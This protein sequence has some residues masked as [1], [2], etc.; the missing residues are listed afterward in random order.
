MVPV[1]ALHEL[2]DRQPMVL[3]AET[4][5]LGE[6]LLIV[7]QQAF[8]PASGMQMQGETDLPQII[9]TFD[10]GPVF[11]IGKKTLSSELA[12]GVRAEMAFCHPTDYLNVA[13]PPRPLFN[14]GLEI[15][16]GI[17]EFSVPL[18]LL[19][20]LGLEE[21][22]TRPDAAAGGACPHPLEQFAYAV[23]PACLHE[24]GGDGDV[25]CR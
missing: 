9:L 19:G 23:Q 8:F 12:E 18:L 17:V 25:A 14:V 15:V 21:G 13:Q 6:R 11:G 7:E 5:L 24:A 22:R 20:D 1:I 2:L 4:E 10:Q 16:S 3:I